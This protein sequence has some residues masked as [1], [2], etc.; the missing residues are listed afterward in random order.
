MLH[1]FDITAH[2]I[3]AVW[4]VDAQ[5]FVASLGSEDQSGTVHIR[6]STWTT[7]NLL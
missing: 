6:G 5:I 4:T 1:S 2:E 3:L 7:I